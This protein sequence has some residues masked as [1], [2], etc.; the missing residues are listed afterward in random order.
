MWLT[1][2]QAVTEY[3]IPDSVLSYYSPHSKHPGDC[4]Y[5]LLDG[6]PV[7]TKKFDVAH[8]GSRSV[9]AHF[10]RPDIERI[11]RGLELPKRGSPERVHV[12]GQGVRWWP[13][14]ETAERIGCSRRSVELWSE[15]IGRSIRRKKARLPLRKHRHGP[16]VWVYHEGDADRIKSEINGWAKQ[17]AAGGE[18]STKLDLLH[19]G[20][21]A[22]HADVRAG[23]QKVNGLAKTLDEVDSKVDSGNRMVERLAA[24]KSTS[25][26]AASPAAGDL[27]PA[28]HYRLK[29]NL[30]ADTLWKARKENRITGEKR[31]GRWHYS[32]AS[33]MAVYPDVFSE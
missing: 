1:R 14:F 13:M 28:D 8:D 21:A 20:Q 22:M 30:Q 17:P 9:I 16:L 33:V 31:H 24:K 32:L 25:S 11:A 10:W 2:K 26:S 29:Y 5:P 19:H 15:G 23:S 12:D 27:F 18:L 3:N 4:S 7:K 6:R